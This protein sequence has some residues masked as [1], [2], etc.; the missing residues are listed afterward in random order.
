MILFCF[1]NISDVHW[2][3]FGVKF[4]ISNGNNVYQYLWYLM[5]AWDI[6]NFNHIGENNVFMWSIGLEMTQ[7]IVKDVKKIRESMKQ[8]QDWQKCYVN[9]R[10]YELEFNECDKVFIKVTPFK[11]VIRFERKGKLAPRFISPYE[12][13][14]RISKEAYKL[15]LP[16]SM[17]QIHNVFHISLLHKYIRDL[18]HVLK[19]K[20]IEL[21]NRLSYKE[22][23][24]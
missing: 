13:I 18:S 21:S 10:R 5:T 19:V 22:R 3:Y 9:Q 12:V 24:V 20:D 14:E 1:P 8:A 15:A 2:S 17:D 16:T 23:L 4:L 11:H 6:S 7:K